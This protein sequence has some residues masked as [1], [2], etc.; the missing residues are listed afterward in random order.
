MLIYCLESLPHLDTSK[1]SL[2]GKERTLDLTAKYRPVQIETKDENLHVPLLTE[3]TDDRVEKIAF[4][5]FS[6][7]IFTFDLMT[8]Y[9]PD[10]I[11]TEDENLHVEL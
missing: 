6:N 5:P 11:E 4:S 9:R 2:F 8:K 10:R 3:F 7:N 1:I